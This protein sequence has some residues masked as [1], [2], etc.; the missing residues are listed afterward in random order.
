M[1]I[2]G[3][4]VH[5]SSLLLTSSEFLLHDRLLQVVFGG[6][7]ASGSSLSSSRRGSGVEGL[8]G[9]AIEARDSFAGALAAAGCDVVV[10]DVVDM[11]FS[12]GA[13]SSTLVSFFGGCGV[14]STV[15]CFPVVHG[16]I[17]RNSSK[18]NT[19]G[20]QQS[21]PT[22]CQSCAL[23]RRQTSTHLFD[24]HERLADQDDTR[25]ALPRP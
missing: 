23:Y 3:W 12:R 2:P 14:S 4:Y 1:G 22:K 6:V 10:P 21:Q 20:L 17:S 15:E 19:R 7:G 9:G 16:G 18:V 5:D 13:S 25:R 11:G 24:P 8:A